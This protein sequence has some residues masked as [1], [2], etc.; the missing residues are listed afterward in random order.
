MLGPIWVHV[1]ANMGSHEWA[2]MDFESKAISARVTKHFVTMSLFS[3]T[4]NKKR[5]MCQMIERV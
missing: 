4:C 1:R 3:K 2:A 5:F